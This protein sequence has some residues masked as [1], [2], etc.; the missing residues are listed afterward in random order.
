MLQDTSPQAVYLIDDS[1]EDAQDV[2]RICES[3]SIRVMSFGSGD[4]FLAG[5]GAKEQGCALID[6]LMP[7]MNGLALFRAISNRQQPLTCVLMTGH[8][9]TASCRAAFRA[10]VFDFIEKDA[11]PHEFLDA[12]ERALEDA[13]KPANEVVSQRDLPASWDALTLRENEVA[14]QLM[15]GFTLKKISSVLGISVQ[16]ASKHRTRVFNK[17]KVASEVELLKLRIET[18]SAS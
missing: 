17:L 4:S 12:I 15:H 16:T 18:C 9:D 5:V 13:K 14:E 7:G 11:G 3:V 8:G 2:K 10:G 6:M 1:A